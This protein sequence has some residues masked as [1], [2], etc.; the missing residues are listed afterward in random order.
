MAFPNGLWRVLTTLTVLSLAM[1]MI[2]TAAIAAFSSTRQAA[3]QHSAA[4]ITAPAAAGTTVTMSCYYGIRATVTVEAY[5]K[6]PNANYHEIKLYNRNKALEFTGDLSQAE[7][8]TYTSGL[9]L[10]G[11]WTYEIRGYYKVPNS[12][13]TWAGAEPLKGTLT[14]S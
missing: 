7:G 10:I 13:N 3:A 5:S 11:T 1:S 14:C 2:P 6:A 9:E 8:R 12:T 4:T